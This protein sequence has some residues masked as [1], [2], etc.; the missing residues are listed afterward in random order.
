MLLVGWESEELPGAGFGAVETGGNL[1]VAGV[2]QVLEAVVAYCQINLAFGGV[3]RHVFRYQLL[4][5]T[6]VSGNAKM[7]QNVAPH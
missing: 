3:G 1:P 2:D 6:P 4:W 5:T 7:R